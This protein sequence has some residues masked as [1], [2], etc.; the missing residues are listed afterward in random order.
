[1]SVG[2]VL[3]TGASGRI[4]RAVVA[5]LHEAGARVRVLTRRAADVDFPPDVT[6]CEGDLADAASLKPALRGVEALF[7]FTP[8]QGHGAL[9]A[10][11]REAG[12]QRGVLLS[13]IATQKA[14]PRVNPIAARHAA[15]EQA[16]LVSG[17][18]WTLLRPDT[19]A[20]NT[21]EWASGIRSTGVVRAPFGAS[22]RCPIH[23]R[24]IAAMAALALLHPGHEG[25]AYWLTGPALLSQIEQVQAIAVATGRPLRFEELSRAAALADMAQ[26]MPL[27]VAE[28]LLDYLEK[29]VASP[30]AVST[31]VAQVLGREALTFATW[32]QDHR[33][34]FL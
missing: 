31:D 14:D 25:R 29:S 23:E 18:A 16:L 22:R 21:L 27:A 3:V 28:R 24:D 8:P 10:L 12:V 34:D 5:R 2:S 19:F 33:A 32:A 26:R 11:A 17:L 1:M 9:A 15:A 20:A 7:L 30:P 4:G 6:V 13:S